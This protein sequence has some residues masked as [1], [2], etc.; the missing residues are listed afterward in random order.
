MVESGADPLSQSLPTW[1][2]NNLK[3]EV[4]CVYD[5]RLFK[6]EDDSE[7][8]KTCQQESPQSARVKIDPIHFDR[9][10]KSFL[11]WLNDLFG[12]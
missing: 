12:T 9:G 10:K 2:I 4:K 6:K 8:L 1:G 7:Y 11:V 3:K 5:S